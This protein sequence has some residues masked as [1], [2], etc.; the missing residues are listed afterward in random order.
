MQP[1]APS[2]GLR[3]RRIAVALLMIAAVA[4]VR[5]SAGDQHQVFDMCTAKCDARHECLHQYD[6]DDPLSRN[7]HPAAGEPGHALLRWSCMDHCVYDCMW[8]T[9]EHF[10]SY[11]LAVPQFYGK[12]PFVRVLGVQEPA[13]AAFSV[14]NFVAHWG[15][16]RAFRRR[17]RS[18]SPMYY[19]WHVF[20]GVGDD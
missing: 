6:G 9:V 15:G 3:G 5:A 18:N 10:E 17:V 12:W 8:T 13:S 20:G 19:A 4:G 11:A 2:A 16:L 14:L 1:P 7:Q